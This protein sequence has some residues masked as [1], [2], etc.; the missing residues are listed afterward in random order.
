MDTSGEEASAGGEGRTT[1]QMKQR[2]TFVDWDFA[3]V[4]DIAENQTYPFLRLHPVGD[5]NYNGRVDLL[6]LAVL[7]EHWLEGVE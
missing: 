4:W 5:L 6:D 1:A 2:A 7:A 3:N